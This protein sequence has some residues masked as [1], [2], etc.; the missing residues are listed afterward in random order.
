[1]LKAF[2]RCNMEDFQP[3]PIYLTQIDDIHWALSR[4]ISF[5]YKNKTLVVPA[6]FVTDLATI[7]KPL[8]AFYHR[9]GSHTKACIIHDFLYVNEY[10]KKFA[11]NVFKSVLKAS[12]VENPTRFLF[13]W[14]VRLFGGRLK[15]FKKIR[16]ERYWAAFKFS[17]D[18]DRNIN[19]H[20]TALHYPR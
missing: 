20:S 12:G 15:S 11:D 14:G 8:T 1:L 10:P 5:R 17:R 3:F 2:L 4:D 7:P 19:L 13:V 16:D 9:Y 6:G 18:T